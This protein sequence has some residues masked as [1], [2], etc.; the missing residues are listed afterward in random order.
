MDTMV[1]QGTMAMVDTMVIPTDTMD[2]DTLE[3]GRLKQNLRLMLML[4]T[5]DMDTMV[6]LTL[7]MDTPD[8]TLDTILMD[9]MDMDS[10]GK[11]NSIPF[12]KKF[13]SSPIE[14]SS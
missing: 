7:I 4:P 2:T 14:L 10:S 1:I 9:T 13:L 6:I 5:M 12:Q 8:T 3:R 11:N